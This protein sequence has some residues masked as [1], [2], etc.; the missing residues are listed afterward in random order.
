MSAR[1]GAVERR[2]L[3]LAAAAC[4]D[5]PSQAVAEQAILDGTPA[6]TDVA[7][8]G[9][10]QR[11]T[12]CGGGESAAIACTGTLVAPRVVVT[13]A[14]CLGLAAP[15]AHQ[16]FFGASWADGGVII[17]VIGGRAHPQFDPSTHANDI[18]A[19]ILESDAPAPPIA[20]R[21]EP[22]PDLTGTD[23][24]LV[25][26]GV[27]SPTANE[28]GVRR[29]GVARVTA[30]G[31][32]DVRVAPSPAMSC[33]GDSGGPV[34]A[35]TG[36][37]EQLIGVTSYGDPACARFGVAIRVDRHDNLY[38]DASVWGMHPAEALRF[39]AVQT[40]SGERTITSLCG[41]AC[42]RDAVP[43]AR[44]WERASIPSSAE[45]MT[46]ASS[47]TR[48]TAATKWTR[49]GKARSTARTASAEMRAAIL[50]LAAC[51]ASAC[52]RSESRTPPPLELTDVQPREVLPHGAKSVQIIGDNLDPTKPVH[53][54]F[55]SQRSPRVVVI[56]KTMIH[57]Q[58]PPG[59]VG[60]VDIR[61]EQPGRPP[62][63]ASGLFHY[64]SDDHAHAAS[65]R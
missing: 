37:G 64:V 58:V 20:M 57:A 56:S 22:L 29:G 27:T 12:A 41:N 7:V 32:D 9:I 24:R 46:S 23:V 11:T 59:S 33:R 15:N 55:G 44:R 51:L 13:A 25:G 60:P 10:A 38:R 8:V 39:P 50:V 52:S 17:P 45:T 2:A 35:D 62:V 42:N 34:L 36:D 18:A 4:G 65:A 61:V 1:G 63:V 28:T 48:A 14:H 43:V 47:A 31:A 30:I 26:S 3:G 49:R 54:A 53:V 6:A 19:L 5:L 21:A 40:V 16:V